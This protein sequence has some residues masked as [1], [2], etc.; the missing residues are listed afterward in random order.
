MKHIIATAA[1]AAAILA[2]CT[3]EKKPVKDINSTVSPAG[4][5]T[6]KADWDSIAAK[7]SF[8]EWF[9]DA[10]FGIFIHWGV[11]AVP[12]FDNEWYPRNMYQQDHKV[13]K[14]HAER[15]GSQESFGYKD[16]IPMFKAERFNANEWMA[17]FKA[18]G[19]KY[20]VPVAEHH[21][22][23]SMYASDR[24]HWNSVDMGPKRDIVGELKAAAEREGIVFGLSSHRLENAWFYNGGMKFPSDVQDT[25]ISLYG[26]R[27][28]GGREDYNEAVALDWL[29][30][31]HELIDKYQPQLFWFDWTVDSDVIRPYFNKFLAYYY[32]SAIDWGKQVAVNTKSGYPTN[33]QVGD[34]ERGKLDSMRKYPWQTDTSVGKHSWCYTEGEENKTPEQ[35]VHDL[36][37]I[38]SK[39]G[40]LLLNIGPKADGT[41][42]G[43]QANVLLN[44]GQWL[45]I[46]GEAIYGSRCWKKH[47]EGDKGGTAGSFTDNAATEYSARDIRFTS[48]GNTLYAIV[49]SCKEPQTIVRS[50]TP[51][52]IGSAKIQSVRLLGS[53]DNIEWELTP[54]GLKV[55]FPDKMPCSY[56]CSIRIDFDKPAGENLPSEMIDIP[57]KH[58]S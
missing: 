39:N 35:I 10:K 31:V 22:G 11:Y 37:D 20:V 7:Y 36:V 28:P 46:N 19:A 33:I 12:A 8:P 55:K 3:A 50:L 56:A 48:K 30:H 34:V 40:N 29:A 15:Y 17:L 38:V 52:N 27:L 43:E 51:E 58:G 53:D 57:F 18:S 32:N 16:F 26:F 44:I 45:N 41:I 1:I 14:S 4:T 2:S 24:N 54:D 21:D 42:T 23:F 13:F 6:F 49:L 25:S 47:G 9:A 5:S